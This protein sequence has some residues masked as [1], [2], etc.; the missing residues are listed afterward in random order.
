MES[1]T[2]PSYYEVCCITKNI[3]VHKLWELPRFTNTTPNLNRGDAHPFSYV[4]V[5]GVDEY[6]LR[7]AIL[8]RFDE[9]RQVCPR[10]AR[11]HD[12]STYLGHLATSGMH[13]LEVDP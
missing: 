2:R 5:Q 12:R 8:L 11:A 7:P 10:A 4:P 1:E 6:T 13:T 3:H 9:N